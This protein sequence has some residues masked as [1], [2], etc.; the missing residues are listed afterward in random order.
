MSTHKPLSF[1]TRAQLYIQLAQM[2]TA[3]LPPDRAFGILALPP[4]AQPR[5]EAMRK[6]IKKTGDLALAGEKCGLFTRLDARLIRASMNAGSQANT[7]R[8]L[9]DYYTARAMQ[10]STI[11][12]RLLMPAFVFIA[13]LMIAPIP[14]LFVGAISTAGYAWQVAKPL[15]IV[16]AAYFAFRALVNREA[17]SK[18]KSLYQRV[19]I[20]GPMFVRR[21]L[22][23]FFE[24]LGLMLEAGI[25]M[26][27]AIPTALDTV[28]DGDIK[29]EL[30]KIKPRIEKG[31]TFA[32][33]L[34]DIAYINSDHVI[35]FTQTGESSGTLPE[36]LLR[37]TAFETGQINSFYAQ[38]AEWTPRVLYGAVM[39]WM[40]WSLISGGA[41][42]PR[43]PS[44]L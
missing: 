38:L 44:D 21:N 18:G 11:K 31:A 22:R 14:S 7:Y 30:A 5:A 43:V 32:E 8:R 3:G 36:M 28:E 37:Y 20:Y 40:A 42:M 17:H 19:P 41:F 4:E 12:S 23:D 26:L 27:D 9:A 24:S 15:M 29:R 34:R 10:L 2:E 25:S 13:A 1:R 39:L 33:A 16:A 6:L 35:Q